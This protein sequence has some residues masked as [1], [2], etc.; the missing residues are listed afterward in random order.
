L[1][2]QDNRTLQTKD[3]FFEP[4]VTKVGENQIV[5]MRLKAGANEYL[6]YKYVLKPNDYMI[7]FDV[8]SQ[9]L[10]KV[11]NTSKPLDLEWKLKGIRNEKGIDYENRY[12]E[13][14]FE[15]EDKKIDYVGQGENK[16]ENGNKVSFVA[17]KQH[18]FFNTNNQNTFC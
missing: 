9:G 4:T 11:L 15:Y 7:D 3:L 8:R 16:E 17:F 5:S 1:L 12:A 18:F 14:Y 2:T 13:I 6:E 10:N